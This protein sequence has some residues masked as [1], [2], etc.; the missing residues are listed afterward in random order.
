MA[1][2]CAA[3]GALERASR[4][5]CDELAQGASAKTV[6]GSLRAEQVPSRAARWMRPRSDPEYR[7]RRSDTGQAT[8]KSSRFDYGAAL[9]ARAAG[10]NRSGRRAMARA[11][12]FASGDEAL[13]TAF[14]PYMRALAR[15][16]DVRHCA[17]ES[18]LNQAASGAP[19]A[20]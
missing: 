14:A 11:P 18:A 15:L 4:A 13:L 8:E 19:V 6:W 17:D 12:L 2:R 20:F 10:K 7:K 1:K 9:S 3:S 16:S 5:F